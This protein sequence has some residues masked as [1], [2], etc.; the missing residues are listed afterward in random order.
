MGVTK[1]KI[2][3]PKKIKNILVITTNFFTKYGWTLKSSEVR[4]NGEYLTRTTPYTGDL[5]PDYHLAE[6]LLL[7]R[8]VKKTPQLK[9][10]WVRE[11]IEEH[12]ID[13]DNVDIWVSTKKD[14]IE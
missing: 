12:K 8:Y 2:G 13:I 7:M 3:N 1:A 9:I 11:W 10:G 4:V 14:M 5:D 6:M